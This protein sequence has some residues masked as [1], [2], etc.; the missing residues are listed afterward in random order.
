MR[1]TAVFVLILLIVSFSIFAESYTY[2]DLLAIMNVNNLELLTQ[3]EVIKTASL[4]VKDAKANY[5][6]TID[7]QVSGTYMVN[8]PSITKDDILGIANQIPALESYIP[9]LGGMLPDEINIIDKPFMYAAQ[10]NLTQPIFTW[11]KV[12][13]AVKL[14]EKIL[15]IRQ[16]EKE[17]KIN[18]LSVELE[19][20]LGGLYYAREILDLLNKAGEDADRLIEIAQ[21]GYENGV[22]LIDDYNEARLSKSELDMGITEA[23]VQIASLM[24]NLEKTVGVDMAEEDFTFVPDEAHYYEV[25]KM[26]RTDLRAR[27]V[28]NANSNI[29][30][31]SMSVEAAELGEDIAKGSIYGKP[32]LALQVGLGYT[33]FVGSGWEHSGDY[34]LNISVGLQTTLWDG[35]KVL[36][37]IDRSKSQIT[38][39]N[40]T[41][42]N[43]KSQLSM[44][45]EENF[46]NMD[47]AISR[48]NYYQ[49]RND[50][51]A[52][53]LETLNKQHDIGYA[54]E[55]DILQ[56]QIEIY[57]NQ[58]SLLQEKANL[59]QASLAVEYI[60]GL[61]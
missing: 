48:I 9:I 22:M 56:K 14:Y 46:R 36:N 27:A 8:P 50:V 38:S 18:S 52:S 34:S 13:N 43:A 11:G 10:L 6:P 39:A 53:E 49:T 4:D 45:L 7:L 15:E 1:K 54:G 40:I 30:M 41:L 61:R 25:A 29:K 17:D 51:L 20:Y 24:D 44:A 60:A 35:G 47:L 37:N 32:D 26:D 19:G 58:I 59:M 21:S 55:S 33:G 57:Q 3:D 23:E 2:E 42:E 31:A 28:S 12:T 5:S 16:V